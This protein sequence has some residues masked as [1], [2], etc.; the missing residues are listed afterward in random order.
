MRSNSPPHRKCRT[1][2][3]PIS[4]TLCSAEPD[5]DLSKMLQRITA[6]HQQQFNRADPAIRSGKLDPVLNEQG[7]ELE[8]VS[9]SLNEELS[10]Q[11]VK[12][13]IAVIL[14]QNNIGGTVLNVRCA[15]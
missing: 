15:R 12:Q 1:L 2:S 5:T 11:L 10:K 13:S 8:H 7:T 9:V 14:N 6:Q 3:L 4:D